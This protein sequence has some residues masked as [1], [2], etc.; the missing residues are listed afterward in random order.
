M[1]VAYSEL[2][3]RLEH[4]S[5]II[6]MPKRLKVKGYDAVYLSHCRTRP[7]ILPKGSKQAFGYFFCPWGIL[8]HALW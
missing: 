4:K 2:K 8:R 5:R 3:W 1:D 6:Q 7:E